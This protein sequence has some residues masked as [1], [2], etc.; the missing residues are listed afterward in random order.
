VEYRRSGGDV[1]D[2][3]DVQLEQQQQLLQVPPPPP[4]AATDMDL[5]DNEVAGIHI[6]IGHRY[7]YVTGCSFALNLVF[8]FN[9]NFFFFTVPC[10][11]TGHL[12]CRLKK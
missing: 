1:T 9:F 2:R 12:F 11:S 5:S 8:F 7:Q 4:L 6:V 10:S 3:R